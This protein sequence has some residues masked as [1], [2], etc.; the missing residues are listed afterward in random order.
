MKKGI[1]SAISMVAGGMIGAGTA[2]RINK[3]KI[4][5]IQ[6][7]SDKHLALFLM[8]NRWVKVKQEGKNLSIYFESHRYKKI[9]IYG[10]SYVGES[11][12]EE[13]RGTETE[14]ICGID[15]K[16]KFTYI[17]VI[18]LDDPLPDV[19]AVVVTAIT[20]FEEIQEKLCDKVSCP[21]ISLEDILNE[22]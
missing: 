6:M 1:L 17:D 8:M 7:M 22:V 16:V 14:V 9:C 4:N 18:T 13:L 10:M 19:D 15:Q 20:F 2:G 12:V 3:E 21:I 5:K 11:L